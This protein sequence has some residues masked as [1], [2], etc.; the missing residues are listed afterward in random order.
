MCFTLKNNTD[1]S[2]RLKDRY[3]ASMSIK[4]T[5]VEL[6]AKGEMMLGAKME[7]KQEV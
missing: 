4:W 6:F 3:N 7:L 2:Q 1:F 5:E